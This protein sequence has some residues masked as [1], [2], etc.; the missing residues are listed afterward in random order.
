MG[1]W[2]DAVNHLR[3][4]KK[5]GD[6]HGSTAGQC[7][8]TCLSDTYYVDRPKSVSHCVCVLRCGDAPR[9]SKACQWLVSF[10]SGNEPN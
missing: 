10:A 4:D 6:K 1:G 9:S 5:V 2:G 8:F 3:G 7:G